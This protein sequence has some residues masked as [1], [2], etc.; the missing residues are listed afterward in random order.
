MLSIK[1]EKKFKKIL[2]IS[3]KFYFTLQMMA[4]APSDTFF[5]QSSS[6]PPSVH[7]PPADDVAV[8]VAFYDAD[9]PRP[10]HKVLQR[11]PFCAIASIW[12]RTNC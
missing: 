1:F 12:S 9:D 10:D 11:L 5:L 3:K 2:K 7:A 8:A 4:A 6:A